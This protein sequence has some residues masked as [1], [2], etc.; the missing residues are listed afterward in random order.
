L[1]CIY[2]TAFVSRVVVVCGE[3]SSERIDPFSVRVSV[4]VSLLVGKHH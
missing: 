4:S 2:M 1:Q 3:D